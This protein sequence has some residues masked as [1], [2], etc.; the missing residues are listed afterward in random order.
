MIHKSTDDFTKVLTPF[1]SRSIISH[2]VLLSYT[3]RQGYD[4]SNITIYYI[5][6]YR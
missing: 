3:L 1:V 2:I 6:M 4:I 5:Y